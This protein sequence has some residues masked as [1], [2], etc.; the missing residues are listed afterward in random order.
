[1]IRKI[2]PPPALLHNP[3]VEVQV[4]S[5]DPSPKPG[6]AGQPCIPP[7]EQLEVKQSQLDSL[8]FNKDDSSNQIPLIVLI[9]LFYSVAFVSSY[10]WCVYYGS[11]TILELKAWQPE[12]AAS[13]LD[14]YEASDSGG[15]CSCLKHGS[16]VRGP[17]GVPAKIHDAL[18]IEKQSQ[19][20]RWTVNQQSLA[21]NLPQLFKGIEQLKR[22]TT[23]AAPTT[24]AVL[25][26]SVVSWAGPQSGDLKLLNKTSERLREILREILRELILKI[27]SLTKSATRAVPKAAGNPAFPRF[28]SLRSRQGAGGRPKPHSGIAHRPRR[29]RGPD[30][31]WDLSVIG[32][33]WMFG[34]CSWLVH[35]WGMVGE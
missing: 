21:T 19:T 22:P 1:M 31:C 12:G 15:V 5:I 23:M 35:G 3:V 10:P 34:E 32:R 11:H 6:S 28:T 14:C 27:L 8:S 4:W 30:P 33:C 16:D 2:S 17:G 24:D 29:P 25:S 20:L 13:R 18:A 26:R 9:C 7:A